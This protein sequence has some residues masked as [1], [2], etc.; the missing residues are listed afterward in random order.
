MWR[1]RL[2]AI[3][4][5]NLHD[6]LEWINCLHAGHIIIG[7]S[8]FFSRPLT[9]HWTKQTVIGCFT[10]LSDVL[11]AIEICDRVQ[12]FGRCCWVLSIQL[13]TSH[14]S[15]LMYMVLNVSLH[16]S[17]FSTR[18]QTIM[19]IWIGLGIVWIWSIPSFH[20]NMTSTSSYQCKQEDWNVIKRELPCNWPVAFC[21]LHQFKPWSQLNL[22]D[23]ICCLLQM[24]VCLDLSLPLFW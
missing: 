5:G 17:V 19:H 9:R 6:F 21:V 4:A 13:M 2:R 1:H 14:L 10:C 23:E 16:S 20:S 3:V 11:L 8:T 18:T 22:K 7:T 24:V 15:C 12:T